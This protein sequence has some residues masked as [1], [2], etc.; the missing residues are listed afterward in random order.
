M[1]NLRTDMPQTAAW[2]DAL[3]DAFGRD[4]IDA[5]IKKAM[6][7]EPTFYAKEGEREFGT[8]APQRGVL[9]S[10]YLAPKAG[11]K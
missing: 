11:G 10:P 2:I 7:G 4:M 8:Q 5:Q 9:V 1:R 3:R 6:K